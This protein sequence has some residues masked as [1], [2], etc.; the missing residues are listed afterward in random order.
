MFASVASMVDLFNR[1]NIAG[2]EKLGYKVD[3]AAN[4]TEGSVYSKEQ[5]E[6]FRKELEDSGHEVINVPVPRNITD[7]KNKITGNSVKG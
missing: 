4:F 3:V 2:L 6:N 5:A 7:I 1:D